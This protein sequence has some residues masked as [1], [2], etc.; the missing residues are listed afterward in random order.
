MRKEKEGHS[1][2]SSL[3]IFPSLPSFV[4]HFEEGR[5]LVLETGIYLVTSS[6]HSKV[7][8]NVGTLG[9]TIMIGIMKGAAPIGDDR[10]TDDGDNISK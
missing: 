6:I 1:F 9:N 7:T 3:I 2:L 4:E 5:Q 10:C 8:R